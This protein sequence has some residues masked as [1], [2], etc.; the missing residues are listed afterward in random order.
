MRVSE[1]LSVWGAAGYGD[2]SLTLE[3]NAEDGT[4]GR[5]DSGPT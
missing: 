2:G 5:G 3:P 1:R 4:R